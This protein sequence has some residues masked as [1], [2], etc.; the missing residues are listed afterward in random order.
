MAFT[1][2]TQADL[3]VDT[4]DAPWM[5]IAIAEEKKGVAE[6][7]PF[8]V[9]KSVMHLEL[10]TRNITK[11]PHLLDWNEVNTKLEE[12]FARTVRPFAKTVTHSLNP[13]INKYF[14]GVTTDPTRD[15]RGKGR[16]WKIESVAETDQGWDVTPWCA[17]YVNWCLG[18]V[19]NLASATPRRRRGCVTASHSPSPSTDALSS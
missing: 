8:R 12:S 15:P 3:V 18:R 16:S 9:L 5:N 6:A 2:T 13:E 14:D 17:A 11:G 19:D 4:T 7:A 10:T 1:P